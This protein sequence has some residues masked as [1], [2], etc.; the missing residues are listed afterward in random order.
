MLIKNIRNFHQRKMSNITLSN[1]TCVLICLLTRKMCSWRWLKRQLRSEYFMKFAE[2]Y[3]SW[4]LLLRK[5]ATELPLFW[6]KCFAK[7]IFLEIFELFAKYNFNKDYCN[8]FNDWNFDIDN[9]YFLLH[10]KLVESGVL[11]NN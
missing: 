7:Y 6:T 2:R 11:D 4:R 10:V 3:P 8:K 5:L 9:H 1:L